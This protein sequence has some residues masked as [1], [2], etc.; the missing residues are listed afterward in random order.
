VDS[1][2]AAH[3]VEPDG[4]VIAVDMT[5]A[6]LERGRE[7]VALTGLSQVEYRQGYAEALPVEDGAANLVISNGVINLSPDKAAVFR[8]AFRVLK[9]GG[10][11]QVADIVVHKDIPP[12]GREDIAVWTA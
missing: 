2:L 6:M 7:N 12:D 9:P 8:E 11:L 5:P 10:R 4:R 3:A 1:F